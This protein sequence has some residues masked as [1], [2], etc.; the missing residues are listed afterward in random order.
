MV[1]WQ[2]GTFIRGNSIF[3][4]YEIDFITIRIFLFT[5]EEFFPFNINQH[6]L[7]YGKSGSLDLSSSVFTLISRSLFEQRKTVSRETPLVSLDKKLLSLKR[8]WSISAPLPPPP[9]RWNLYIHFLFP[10]NYRNF[11]I[12]IYI[13]NFVNSIEK[14]IKI[15]F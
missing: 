1:P 8:N 4:S 13:I 14:L 7:F 11:I 5:L 2:R 12:Y 6:A 3:H 10:Q 15:F 9:P